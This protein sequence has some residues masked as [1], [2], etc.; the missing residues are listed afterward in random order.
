M[1]RITSPR[2]DGGSSLEPVGR[3]NYGP[4]ARPPESHRRDLIARKVLLGLAFVIL[5]VGSLYVI[6]SGAFHAAPS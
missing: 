4:E 2:E 5:M 1:D 3:V 6:L